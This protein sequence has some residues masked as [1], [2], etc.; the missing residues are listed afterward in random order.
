MLG[1]TENAGNENA[2]K[3]NARHENAGNENAENENAGQTRTKLAY[4]LIATADDHQATRIGL[5]T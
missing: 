5:Y 2:G 4:C 3:K 1:A